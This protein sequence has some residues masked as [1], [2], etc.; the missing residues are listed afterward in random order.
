MQKSSKNFLLD[1]NVAIVSKFTHSYDIQL[2][3]LLVTPMQTKLGPSR[4]NFRY[5]L[6]VKTQI[7]TPKIG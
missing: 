4:N 5:L 1:I 2:Q 3:P 7:F 6:K